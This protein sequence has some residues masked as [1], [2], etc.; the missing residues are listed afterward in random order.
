LVFLANPWYRN[1]PRMEWELFALGAIPVGVAMHG[2]FVALRRVVSTGA[3]WAAAAR[4]DEADMVDYRP[5]RH[6]RAT[7]AVAFTVLMAA[8]PAMRPPALAASQ[9]QKEASPANLDSRAAWHYLAARNRPDQRVLDDL[10]A[11]GDL[12]M[13]ADYGIATLFRNPP[14]IAAA[15]NSWKERLYLRGELR[16]IRTDAC[17]PNLITNSTSPM[18]SIPRSAS[19]AAA[20]RSCS[21]NCSA[22]GTSPRCSTSDQQGCS[23]SARSRAEAVVTSEQLRPSSGGTPS[24]T[25]TNGHMP[26][27]VC[28]GKQRIG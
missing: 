14:L 20:H 9:Y 25:R 3:L 17:V 23:G 4:A 13:Y 12:W 1:A 8:F 28:P 21:P 11:H 16:H 10:E 6:W 19:A 22:P 26:T 15:S 5:R 18:S 27:C 24:L 7:V 2:V